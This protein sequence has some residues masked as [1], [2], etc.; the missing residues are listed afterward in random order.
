MC[1]IFKCLKVELV[2]NFSGT[3]KSLPDSQHELILLSN[4]NGIL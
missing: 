3:G 2:E 1:D 4:Q